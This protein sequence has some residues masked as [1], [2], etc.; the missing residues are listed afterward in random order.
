MMLNLKNEDEKKNKDETEHSN[1][2]QSKTL[3]DSERW[4]LK[5]QSYEPAI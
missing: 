5:I 4:I 3:I 1:S 2:D